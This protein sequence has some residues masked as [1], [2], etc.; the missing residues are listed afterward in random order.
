MFEDFV[1]TVQIRQLL[2]DH[3]LLSPGLTATNGRRRVKNSGAVRHAEYDAHVVKKGT[4]RQDRPSDH[5]PVSV[6]L[7]Y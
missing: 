2:L 1:P 4:R 5:R 6:D 3:I 7:R